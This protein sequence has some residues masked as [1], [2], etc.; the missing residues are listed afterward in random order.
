M[1]FI[2]IGELSPMVSPSLNVIMLISLI[3]SC[4]NLF[5]INDSII[6]YSLKQTHPYIQ[7]RN[8][9]HTYKKWIA[10]NSVLNVLQDKEKRVGL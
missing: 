1:Q 2:L 9:T 8:A 6:K 5:N 4:R 10:P 7:L 3:F